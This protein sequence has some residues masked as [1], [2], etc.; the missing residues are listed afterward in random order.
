[1]ETTKLI[2]EVPAKG[3]TR[4]AAVKQAT[5][6]AIEQ[7]T[8]EG[9]NVESVI[10]RFSRLKA[11]GDTKVW[12]VLAEVIEKKADFPPKDDE[13]GDDA[14]SDDLPSDLEDVL[15]E[16]EEEGDDAD[17]QGLFDDAMAALKAFADAAGVKGGDDDVED[18]EVEPP[19]PPMGDDGPP[20][21]PSDGPP[22]PPFGKKPPMFASYE[23]PKVIE[24]DAKTA[25]VKV[26]R[27][28]ALA[29]ARQLPRVL[30]DLKGFKLAKLDETDTH[31][32]AK[33]QR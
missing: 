32:I 21:P 12:Q 13:G 15:P 4:E 14:P 23:L 18:S 10:P 3:I 17:L 20:L 22:K 19:T 26:T 7:A 5:T 9:Y 25:S 28:E 6:D 8:S 1:M 29:D 24:G 11:E 16:D 33:F 31:F 30:P 2:M 27:K